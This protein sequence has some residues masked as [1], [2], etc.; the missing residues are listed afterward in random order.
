MSEPN[1]ADRARALAQQLGKIVLNSVRHVTTDAGCSL[2]YAPSY[3]HMLDDFRSVVNGLV[4]ALRAESEA[5]IEQLQREGDEA[6]ERIEAF[7]DAVRENLPEV[8]GDADGNLETNEVVRIETVGLLYKELE[9]ERDAA[10]AAVEQERATRADLLKMQAEEAREVFG[11]EL[12]EAVEQARRDE[13]EACAKLAHELADRWYPGW[14]HRS[15]LPSA[16]APQR[17]ARPR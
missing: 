9:R 2:A 1:D 3:G 16:P 6:H 14:P 12:R 7:E 5:R 15:L 8:T 11:V 4:V 17:R 13:R 10:L